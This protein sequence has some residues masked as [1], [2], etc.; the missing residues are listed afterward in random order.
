MIGLARLAL[1]FAFATTTL[2]AQ[3]PAPAPQLQLSLAIYSFKQRTEVWRQFQPVAVELSRLMTAQLGKSVVVELNV[4]KTYEDCLEQFVAGRVDMVRFGPSS[5]VLAKQRCPGVHLLA[6][7]REDSRKVGLIVVRGD[8]PV[9]TLADLKGKRFA[10]GDSQSTIG[11]YL[12]Q[13]ELANAGVL[14]S[15]L[16]SFAFLDRHDNVFKSVEIGDHDAGAMHIDTFN[17]LNEKTPN[18]LRVLHAFDNAPKAWLARKGLEPAV[19]KALT[20]SLLQVKSPEA[21]KALKVPGFAATTDAEFDLVRK[22]MERSEMFAPP[23]KPEATPIKEP[24][25]T[26]APSPGPGKD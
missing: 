18:K 24:V 4:L 17:E 19:A 2:V 11:R 25:P 1:A 15:D 8:S 14:A 23:A 21:L 12:S 3:F 5:Y 22:G 10:F 16:A 13:A 9:Q 6:A 7:E 26:P 20:A